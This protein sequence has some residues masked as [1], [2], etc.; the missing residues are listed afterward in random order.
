MS[1]DILLF[2]SD[3]HAPQYQ[4]GGQM[5]VDTPNLAALR[6][7]GT[8]FDAAY[9]PC[10]LCV[11]ARMAMLSGL[12]PHHTGI[13]TNNDTLPQTTPTFLHAMA[14]AGYETVLVGRMH[15]IGPDQRHGFTRRVAP[16]FTNSGWVRPQK[17]LEQDFGVHTQ[18][19]GY[20]WCIDVVGGG[21]SPV[22]CYDDMVLDA[23]EQ[24]L[25]QPHSKPQLIVVGT[26]GPHFPYVAPPEL[27]LKYLKTA[28]LPATWQGN[29]PWLNAQQRNLQEPNT[30]AEIVL[31]CQAAY[32]G[33]VEH[34]DGL[35]GRARAA[36]D[37]FTQNR[38]T[39]ALFG[40]LS[41]HGD[42]VGEHGIYG[43]KSFFEKSVRIPM[44]FAG[45]GVAAGQRI[46][47][48]SVCW[49]LAPPCV[50]G[51]GQIRCRNP[52]ARALSPCCAV[53]PPMLTAPCGVKLWTS[54]RRAAGP[55]AA[56]PAM[57]SRSSSPA[58]G[59]KSTTSCLM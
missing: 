16:D 15:F 40:Y 57:G 21:A 32:K 7:Q 23:L 11:P 4:A 3:Q 45:S 24:Y 8:A 53:N 31:A 43:K 17:T 42:T 5:P 59:T 55:T 49:T 13:F 44:V 25:A 58:T 27:F 22:V 48:L 37:V 14:T 28:Q 1:P 9:T 33:L 10:P 35:I 50:I 38:G 41:D 20:K 6:E 29:E 19:M 26:Y 39:P 54:C 52:M 34:T 12:S 46:Q 18:T 36:F 30:R 2:I 51:P 47:H 56:W